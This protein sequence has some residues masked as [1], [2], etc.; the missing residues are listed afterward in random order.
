MDSAH[1]T[2]LQVEQDAKMLSNRIRLLQLE[3]AKTHKK[4]TQAI[5]KL[6]RN[7]RWQQEKEHDLNFKTAVKDRRSRQ[8]SQT[9]DRNMVIRETIKNNRIQGQSLL[10]KNNCAL[11]SAI[12]ESSNRNSKK[13]KNKLDMS[14]QKNCETANKVRDGLR[15][16]SQKVARFILNRSQ[17]TQN[18]YQKRIDREEEIRMKREQEIVEM[19]KLES[20]LIKK[21]ERTQKVFNELKS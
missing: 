16:G 17:E 3:E 14:F 2:R 6:K 12:K 10:L 19:E 5:R 20:E 7:Q 11:A 9:H 18:E 8:L 21:L 15:L 1:K 13:I 4:I